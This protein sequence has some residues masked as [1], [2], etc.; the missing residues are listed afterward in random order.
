MPSGAP[1]SAPTATASGSPTAADT[2]A[3]TVSLSPTATVSESPSAGPTV[4]ET[5]SAYPS[6]LPSASP[7]N[8][9][10]APE[11]PS[12]T[13]STSAYPSSAPTVSVSP[14]A[15][16]SDAPTVLNVTVSDMPSSTPTVGETGEPSS[17][18]S[19]A[20]SDVPSETPSDLP[21]AGPTAGLINTT[22]A[23]IQQEYF[24]V[25]E[26]PAF[27]QNNLAAASQSF[28]IGYVGGSEEELGVTDFDTLIRVI[29]AIPN[30][31]RRM[32]RNG[33]MLQAPSVLVSYEQ[34]VVYRP[35]TDTPPTAQELAEASFATP[36][37]RNAFSQF[38]QETG[39]PNLGLITSVGE[40]IVLEGTLAPTAAPTD[41]SDPTPTDSPTAEPDE[42][43]G[44]DGLSTGAI[45]G[46]AIGGAIFV[47]IV[48]YL[49]STCMG[50]DTDSQ[51]DPPKDLRVNTGD[52]AISTLD[53]PAGVNRPTSNESLAGYGDQSVATVDYDYSKAYGGGGDTSVVSSAGGTFGSNARGVDPAVAAASGALGGAASF[54]EDSFSPFEGKTKEELIDV[55]APPGKL[56]VVI[57]TPDDGAPV[58]HAVKSSSVIADKIRVGDKLVA[59]DDEDV[60]SMTAI[61]V[62]KLISRKSANSS[63]KLSLIRTTKM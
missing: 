48:A 13:P 6:D 57:D 28:Q 10:A 4:A 58:V 18:P 41:P 37:Q 23:L 46:I 59:V 22:I 29:S 3:P 26:L 39:D 43:D 52:D 62:S 51:A 14:T 24:G 54:E 49:V 1:S 47:C 17:V 5:I 2:P 61:K 30:G 20:P 31:S 15:M 45:I 25:E 9:T 12:A 55:F 16:S 50:R 34:D 21:S 33:R 32:L 44:D 35:T 27:S 11:I 40:I 19:S 63:R 8:M 42:D 7:T 53:G 38:L 36:E 56:G 60:R